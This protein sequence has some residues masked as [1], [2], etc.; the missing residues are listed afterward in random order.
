MT[1]GGS[2]RAA[3]LAL[4]TIAVFLAGCGSGTS[5]TAPALNL[6]T[7]GPTVVATGSEATSALARCRVDNG[8]WQNC[9]SPFAAFDLTP[10]AH[11]IDVEATHGGVSLLRRPPASTGDRVAVVA[12]ANSAGGSARAT[13]S[14]TVAGAAPGGRI[15]LAKVR[16]GAT[17]RGLVPVSAN[18]TAGAS[19]I[20]LVDYYVDDAIVATAASAP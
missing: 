8:T 2:R 9:V 6:Q 17:L 7:L 14:F 5:A 11:T 15:S 10:G 12:F 13:T 16:P 20:V 4:L 1:A 3:V 18:V 19:R